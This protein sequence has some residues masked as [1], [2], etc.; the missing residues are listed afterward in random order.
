[1]KSLSYLISHM[2]QMHELLVGKIRVFY[3]SSV[4][5]GFNGLWYYLEIIKV[6]YLEFI[7]LF[8]IFKD[9]LSRLLLLRKLIEIL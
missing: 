3:N 9:V 5:N 6:L 4:D 8:T 2:G 1:M 7:G